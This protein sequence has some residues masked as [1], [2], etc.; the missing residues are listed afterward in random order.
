[1]LLS[2]RNNLRLRNAYSPQ[3]NEGESEIEMAQQRLHRLHSAR[4]SR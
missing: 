2:D 1:M 3:K 4:E